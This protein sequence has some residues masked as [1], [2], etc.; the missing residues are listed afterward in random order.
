VKPRNISSSES[1][2]VT[3][4]TIEE[5]DQEEKISLEE[6][7]SPPKGEV[8]VN[9][10]TSQKSDKSPAESFVVNNSADEEEIKSDSSIHSRSS[11]SKEEQE[12]PDRTL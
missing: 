12:D 7:P 6:S 10:E 3:Q 5:S 8:S 4:D 2:E 9:S 1:T 11:E